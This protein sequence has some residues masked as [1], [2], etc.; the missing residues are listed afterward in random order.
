MYLIIELHIGSYIYSFDS[1]EMKAN[2]QKNIKIP[3]KGKVVTKGAFES[4]GV[5]AMESMANGVWIIRTNEEISC[6]VVDVD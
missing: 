3:S 4:I 5:K 6:N 2:E 1:I